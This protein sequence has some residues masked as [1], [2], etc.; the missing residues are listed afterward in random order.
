MVTAKNPAKTKI[1]QL[2]LFNE[3]IDRRYLVLYM[4]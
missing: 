2:I 1:H 3:V 4:L